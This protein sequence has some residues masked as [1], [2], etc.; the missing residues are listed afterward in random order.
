[1]KKFLSLLFAVTII[2]TMLVVTGITAAAETRT[3]VW[4][5]A[6]ISSTAW[7]C[8]A[9]FTLTPPTVDRGTIITLNT[10]SAAA[11]KATMPISG[12]FASGKYV[13]RVSYKINK[14]DRGLGVGTGDSLNIITSLNKDSSNQLFSFKH[15]ADNDIS[16]TR[17]LGAYGSMFSDTAG[18]TSGAGDLAG[19]LLGSDPGRTRNTGAADRITHGEIMTYEVA[20]DTTVGTQNVSRILGSLNNPDNLR[21]ITPLKQLAFIS[22]QDTFNR[23]VI[24]IHR[25]A[26]AG[27]EIEIL[28]LK[29]DSVSGPEEPGRDKVIFNNGIQIS[30]ASFTLANSLGTAIPTGGNIYVRV[31]LSRTAALSVGAKVNTII[32]VYQKD[33]GDLVNVYKEE[34][35]I[36]ADHSSNGAAPV[37]VTA[38]L[39]G[40]PSHPEGYKVKVF[41]WDMNSDSVNSL[42]KS[43][44]R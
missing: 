10:K 1:M 33:T 22:A 24:E 4:D 13:L 32:A 17:P 15:W 3:T 31:Q 5:L 40:F 12:T 44:S 23:F 16:N 28:E 34:T 36:P 21:N 37:N 6:T 20:F 7:V 26:G 29:I 25:N 11:T 42:V 35:E 38:W 2:M 39:A 14:L 43:I 9:N 19:Y 27:T 30:D 18:Y 41:V 8:D